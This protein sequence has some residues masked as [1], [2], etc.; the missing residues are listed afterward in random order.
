MLHHVDVMFA[1]QDLIEDIDVHQAEIDA[2][3]QQA[4]AVT[5]QITR[6]RLYM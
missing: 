4:R 3:V 1:T 6:N 5:Q 2:A